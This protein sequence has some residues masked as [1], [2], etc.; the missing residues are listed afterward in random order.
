MSLLATLIRSFS[1]FDR[2]LATFIWGRGW[3][4][5]LAE[6]KS[7]WEE[8]RTLRRARKELEAQNRRYQERE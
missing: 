4:E 3:R 6:V 2:T 7:T 1:F 8:A 5:R